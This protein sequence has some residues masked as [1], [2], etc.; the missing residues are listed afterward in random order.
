MPNI[1]YQKYI[2]EDCKIAAKLALEHVLYVP[3]WMLKD[4]LI[5]LIDYENYQTNCIFLACIPP[6]LHVGLNISAGRDIPIGIGY[7][8]SGT[9]MYFV[10]QEYRRQG[11]G[12]RLFQLI[13][14]FCQDREYSRQYNFGGEQNPGGSAFFDAMLKPEKVTA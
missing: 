6:T 3:G 12:T 11:I 5:S 4:H 10:K 2:G 9:G 7:L 13:D 1:T 8:C 14:Q